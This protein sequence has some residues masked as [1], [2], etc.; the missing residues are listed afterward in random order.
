MGMDLKEIK[1]RIRKSVDDVKGSCEG[2][3]M[4]GIGMFIGTIYGA[5]ISTLV[6]FYLS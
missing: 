2:V 4:L 6:T 1:L 5:I 3:G